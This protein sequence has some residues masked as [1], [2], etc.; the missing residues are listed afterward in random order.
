MISMMETVD[1][2]PRSWLDGEMASLAGVR[3]MFN[4]PMRTIAD[5]AGCSES[6]VSHV[7][8]DRPW[9]ITKE[10]LRAY[11]LCLWPNLS[12]MAEF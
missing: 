7:E 12:R 9:E 5:A 4:I 11:V 1:G 3:R 2:V 8:N 10:M 6:H